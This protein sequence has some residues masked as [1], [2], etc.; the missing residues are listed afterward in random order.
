LPVFEQNSNSNLCFQLG[1]QIFSDSL[2][3]HISLG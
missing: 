2:T 3:S 1:I